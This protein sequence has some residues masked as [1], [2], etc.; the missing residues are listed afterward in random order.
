MTAYIDHA[1]ARERLSK[2]ID[3]AAIL[4]TFK[5]LRQA[6]KPVNLLLMAIH[7][8]NLS[9]DYVLFG[10]GKPSLP[11]SKSKPKSS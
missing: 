1:A 6:G 7:N 2:N 11:K 4:N 5:Q 10:H 8:A 9:L 3:D